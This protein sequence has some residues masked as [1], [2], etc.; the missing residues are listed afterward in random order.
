MGGNRDTPSNARS[1]PER[2]PPRIRARALAAIAPRA[3]Q[4]SVAHADT[5]RLFTR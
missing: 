5:Q 4:T 1:T 3:T 2:D